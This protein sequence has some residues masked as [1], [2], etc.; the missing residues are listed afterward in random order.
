MTLFFPDLSNNNW[1]SDQDVTNFLSQLKAEGFAGASHKVSEGSYYSDPYW[2]V[3]RDYC[4]ANSIP[5][6]GYHCLTNDDPASQVATYQA[7][8]GSPNMMMDH[9]TFNGQNANL[10][11]FWAVVNAFNAAGINV[12]LE[13]L[14][15]WFWGTIGSP[16]LSG[17]SGNSIVL[18]SSAYPGGAGYASAIYAGAGGD[19]GEGWSSYGNCTPGA[20]QFTDSATIAGHNVDCNAY[21]G[22]DIGVLFGTSAAPLPAPAPA[23]VAPG[24]TPGL[25]TDDSIF[26]AVGALS[27]QLVGGT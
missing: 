2:P 21:L 17:L 18:V 5:Y 6:I 19:A 24:N 14:P 8:G 13:Y 27:A 22:D 11:Q 20:W 4:A 10:D 16:D 15:R 7:N 12:Q 25:P 3:F 26:S 23:P 1:S 9:E